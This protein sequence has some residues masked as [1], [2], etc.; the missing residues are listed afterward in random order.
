MTKPRPE[1]PRPILERARWL[2]LNGVWQLKE[3]LKDEGLGAHW[4]DQPWSDATDVVVPFP[5]ESEASGVH[6]VKPASIFWYQREFSLPSDWQERVC[7]RVGA[8]DHWARVFINGQEVGQHRGGY[9]PF[10]FDISHA[11][12]TRHQPNFH[13]GTGFSVL[14]PAAR[15]TGGYDAVADRLRQCFGH[16]AN[17]L[18]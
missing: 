14:D 17:G 15:K 5:L 6:N 9:A 1:Y 18:A 2:N 3:D 13:P 7:L 10:S 12:N 16:L 4:F 8:C 11:L